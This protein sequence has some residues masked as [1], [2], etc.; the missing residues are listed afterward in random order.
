MSPQ[1]LRTRFSNDALDTASPARIVVMAFERLDRDLS[2]AVAAIEH[3]RLEHAHELLCHAQDLAHELLG[4]LDLDAW[5]HAPKLASIY[6]YVIELLVQANIRKSVTPANEARILLAELG[7]AFRQAATGVASP[8]NAGASVAPG[9]AASG[10]PS[11]FASP[12]NASAPA[13]AAP[14]ARPAGSFSAVG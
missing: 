7:D 2:G 10:A 6:R 1:S 13:F 14:A 11:R 5:E 12:T 3:R 8:P 9:S 4:M